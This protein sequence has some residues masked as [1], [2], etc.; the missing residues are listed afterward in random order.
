MPKQIISG[1]DKIT[2]KNREDSSI[3]KTVKQDE[4]ESDTCRVCKKDKRYKCLCSNA[5]ETA[6][7]KKIDKG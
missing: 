6:E 7:K 2:N 5:L 4:S 3:R 1:N